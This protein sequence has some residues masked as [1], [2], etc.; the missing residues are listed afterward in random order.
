[1]A[2]IVKVETGKGKNKSVSQSI[3]LPNQ[4]RVCNWIKRNPMVKSNTNI[5]VTNTR[6]KK[7]SAG[8]E[9]RFCVRRNF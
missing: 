6:T 5:K 1:M 2:Y 7:T 8:K 4:K 9:S 3:P